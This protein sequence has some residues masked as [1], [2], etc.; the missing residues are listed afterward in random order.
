MRGTHLYGLCDGI[1]HGIIP[2]YAGNTQGHPR[3]RG[4]D[5]DHPR[6]CGEHRIRLTLPMKS[7]GSS[8]HMRGTLGNGEYFRA[9]TG[10]IPAYAGNTS[11]TN[12][13]GGGVR[14][15]PRICGEH[16]TES[17][18]WVV[19]EGSSPHMRGT[20]PDRRLGQRPIGIIPAYAGNTFEVEDC[21]GTTRDHPR[22]CGEHTSP[23][24]VLPEWRGSSPHMR[25][26]HF[27]D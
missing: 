25:G 12:P 24:S 7:P 10:I 26:T 3:R 16:T 1:H 21:G 14:D 23:R 18:Q 5:R 15:H 19:D 4:P 2:A 6:I 22:I 17:W 13:D 11:E 27:M 20:R 9:G 8:P